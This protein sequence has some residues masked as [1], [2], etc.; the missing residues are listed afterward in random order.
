MY[1]FAIFYNH[2]FPVSMLS[3]NCTVSYN[4]NIVCLHLTPQKNHTIC[5][6]GKAH[7]LV[8]LFFCYIH[9]EFLHCYSLLC[10]LPQ[11]PSSWT[12]ALYTNETLWQICIH[13]A[14]CH[15]SHRH[16]MTKTTPSVFFSAKFI[17]VCCCW[18]LLPVRWWQRSLECTYLHYAMSEGLYLWLE[19]I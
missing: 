14:A 19:S 3:L 1:Q 5:F 10:F 2:H 12:F 17:S 18:H 16:G 15:L 11:T 6:K 9:L 7:R 8:C 4:A 13:W